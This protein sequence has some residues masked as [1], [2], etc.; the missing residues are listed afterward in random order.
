MNDTHV[1]VFLTVLE[2]NKAQGYLNFKTHSS[3]K[4]Q[5]TLEGD[6]LITVGPPHP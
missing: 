2:E 3:D 1:S 6:R 4:V 5:L